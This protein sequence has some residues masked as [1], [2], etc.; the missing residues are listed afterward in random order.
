MPSPNRGGGI[1]INIIGSSLNFFKLW[2]IIYI[3]RQYLLQVFDIYVYC[4]E[5]SINCP[6]IDYRLSCAQTAD[7][8]RWRCADIAIS[9]SWCVYV[10][11]WV[12]RCVAEPTMKSLN[13]ITIANISTRICDVRTVR[14]RRLHVLSSSNLSTSNVCAWVFKVVIRLRLFLCTQVAYFACK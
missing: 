13:L 14:R 9:L 11:L 1:I 4:L 10:C 6:Y 8:W 5:V 2:N 3:S 7:Y 12:S